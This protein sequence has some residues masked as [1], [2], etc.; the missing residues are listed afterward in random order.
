MKLKSWYLKKLLLRK[1][2]VI[3]FSLTCNFTVVL[4]EA[5]VRNRFGI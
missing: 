2:W 4:K 5:E 3:R 1:N